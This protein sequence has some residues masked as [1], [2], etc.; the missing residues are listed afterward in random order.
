LIRN[1]NLA[2]A[3]AG[4]ILYPGSNPVTDFWRRNTD[5]T[6]NPFRG[7]YHANAFDLAIMLPYFFVMTILAVY[8]IHRYALVYNYFKNRK[9][10]AGPPPEVKVWPRVTVQLPIYNGVR[11]SARAA[12]YSGAG[13]F[14]G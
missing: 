8:G 11:L 2:V 12:G 1:L 9:N 14:D 4:W 6:M 10:V 3:A 5:P 13:R 7:L